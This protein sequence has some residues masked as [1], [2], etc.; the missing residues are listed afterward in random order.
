MIHDCQL[1]HDIACQL[2]MPHVTIEGTRRNSPINSMKSGFIVTE[3]K[4]LLVVLPI[5]TILVWKASETPLFLVVGNLSPIILSLDG[6][7]RIWD[8]ALVFGIIPASS[9][10]S[11]KFCLVR[12]PF[13]AELGTS[14]RVCPQE[15]NWKEI[16]REGG[17]QGR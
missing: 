6:F 7:S 17:S 14:R 1:N 10:P 5:I 11:I 12:A 8:L 16:S 4:V 3:A 9:A 15:R 2:C 13:F